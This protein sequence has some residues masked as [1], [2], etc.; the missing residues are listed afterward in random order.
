VGV[1]ILDLHSGLRFGLQVSRFS[2][3]PFLDRL[4]VRL[5]IKT[6][7]QPGRQPEDQK[8]DGSFYHGFSLI[9]TMKD[10][11]PVLTIK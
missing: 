10:H 11:M 6:Q 8:Y 4:L 5:R 2:A 1:Q 9:Y 3:I 7:P